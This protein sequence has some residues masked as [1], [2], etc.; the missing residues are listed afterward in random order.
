MFIVVMEFSRPVSG[1]ET[2]SGH[3]LKVSS[4]SRLGLE[5]QVSIS[6]LGLEI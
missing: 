6:N 2:V 4:R 5:L 3:I 1:L